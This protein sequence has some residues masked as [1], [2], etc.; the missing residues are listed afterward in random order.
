MFLYGDAADGRRPVF[1]RRGGLEE[2]TRRVNAGELVPDA[3]PREVDPRSGGVL[4]GA[5]HALIAYN[6]DLATED[7]DVASARRRRRPR[8]ERGDARRA[9]DRPASPASHGAPR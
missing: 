6:L 9:G 3:G 1:F 2:L 4:V 5:R 7:L 8:L